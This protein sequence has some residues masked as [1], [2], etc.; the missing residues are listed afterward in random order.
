MLKKSSSS[1]I[2]ARRGNYSILFALLIPITFGFCALSVDLSYMQFTKMQ[3]QHVAD[4]ASHA[5][6]VRY[7][8]TQSVTLA[9]AAAQSMVEANFVGNGH[10]DLDKV[11]YGRF[12]D[13]NFSLDSVVINSARAY[14]SREEDNAIDLFFAPLL[15][16]LDPSGDNA[17]LHTFEPTTWAITSGRTREI[18]IAQ[19]ITGSF[20]D[21]IGFARQADLAFLDYLNEQ[22]YPGDRISMSLF[23]GGVAPDIYVPLSFVETDYATIDA[24]FSVL[25]SCNCNYWHWD[26]GPWWCID[27]YGNY[28][29]Q[30]QMT[31]CFDYGSQTSQGPGIQQCTD[32]FLANGNP[33]AFQATLMVSDG[34]PCCGEPKTSDRKAAAL[35]AADLAWEN[36]I[37]I[38]SVAYMNGGGSFAFLQSLVRGNGVA[39]E[40]PDPS[41]LEGIMI[42][43]AASIPVVLVE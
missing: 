36:D 22:P 2:E 12:E 25:D 26:Y 4:A 17:G 34:R 40:T 16:V 20:Q 8:S 24:N 15:A 14:V 38:W 43:I 27:H 5:A 28:N 9:D 42:E 3:L 18:C 35:A 33:T 41:E 32:E 10:A 30:P 39:Y 21:D 6:L 23:V 31:S 11:E 1:R 37:H 19:D 29:G 7:R 13:G